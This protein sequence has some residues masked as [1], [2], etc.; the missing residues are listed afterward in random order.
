MVAKSVRE[1][2]Y[3]VCM[4]ECI[5]WLVNCVVIII[6]ILILIKIFLSTPVVEFEKIKKYVCKCA[7][8]YA[9]VQRKLLNVEIKKYD[10]LANC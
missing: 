6:L 5:T 1:E 3:C 4:E 7:N 2:L 10:T 8:K 9:I